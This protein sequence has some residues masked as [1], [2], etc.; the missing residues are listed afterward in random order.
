MP[1]YEYLCQDC[2]KKFEELRSFSSADEARP[3]PRCGSLHNTR[4]LSRVN[5]ISE[6]KSLGGSH[7]CGSCSSSNCSCCG[8]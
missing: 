4:Q 5:A 7:S 2:Q 3:C 8:G 1:L 6:G